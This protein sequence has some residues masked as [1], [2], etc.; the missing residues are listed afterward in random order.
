MKK[1][2]LKRIIRNLEFNLEVHNSRISDLETEAHDYTQQGTLSYTL[3]KVDKELQ[4][5]KAKIA[6]LRQQYEHL[7]LR[8]LNPPHAEYLRAYSEEEEE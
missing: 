3:S 1:Q 2:K 8:V 7:R 4:L 5:A 6:T